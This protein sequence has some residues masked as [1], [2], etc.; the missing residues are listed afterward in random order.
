MEFLTTTDLQKLTGWS[1]PTILKLY[2]RPDFPVLKCG[3][4]YLVSK[5]AFEKWCE[6]RKT[7]NDFGGK[8]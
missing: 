1:K 8:R 3:K 5:T 6:G 4:P 2:D 7:N